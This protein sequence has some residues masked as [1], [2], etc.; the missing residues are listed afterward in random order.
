MSSLFPC[1]GAGPSVTHSAFQSGVLSSPK[2]TRRS[3][4]NQSGNYM[5]T[6]II[7]IIQ[8][9]CAAKS[10]MFSTYT[11]CEDDWGLTTCKK[12]SDTTV[13]AAVLVLT[14]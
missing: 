11:I 8:L 10:L 3:N 13:L 6:G 2:S 1:V 4:S 7:W 14:C 12:K 5:S 9:L